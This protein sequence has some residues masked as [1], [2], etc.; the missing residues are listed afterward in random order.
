MAHPIGCKCQL[1]QD[2]E[3][4]RQRVARRK[5]AMPPVEPDHYADGTPFS[6]A[7]IIV[8]HLMLFVIK[9]DG[10]RGSDL[11]ALAGLLES[12]HADRLATSLETEWSKKKTEM[13]VLPEELRLLH[14]A[15]QYAEAL[16]AARAAPTAGS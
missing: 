13:P 12:A 2:E 6:L 3:A 7:E 9:A 1:C 10:L 11:G 14:A 4:F 15:R 16:A 5:L 8:G